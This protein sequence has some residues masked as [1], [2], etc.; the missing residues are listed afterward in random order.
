MRYAVRRPPNCTHW[1]AL[2]LT[3]PLL[4]SA[5]Q[6]EVRPE[7]LGGDFHALRFVGDT[8]LYGE[9]GGVRRSRDGGRTWSAPDGAGDAMALVQTGDAV[10]LAGHEVLQISRDQGQSWTRMPFGTLPDED[11]HGFAADPVRHEVWYANVMG[12]GLYRTTDG[13]R[14]SFLSAET[15]DAWA[16]AA[17]PQPALYALD[18]EG[19]LV[20][21]DG[22]TW[23]R[24][25]S[26]GAQ[27]L[28]V[29]RVTGAVYA[30]GPQGVARSTDQGRTWKNLSFPGAARLVALHPTNDQQMYGVSGEGVVYRSSDGG[31]TWR[32]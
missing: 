6:R 26:G 30:A 3:L 8:L 12:R 17:G 11:L 14:W 24:R 18:G 31:A 27:H 25:A 4:L 10:I 7:P 13:Q 20:S 1:R 2:V 19:L 21:P 28:D 5:C 29:H 32:K 22:V 23:T 9:H 16:L 15:K